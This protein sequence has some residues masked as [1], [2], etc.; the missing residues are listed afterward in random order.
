MR[1]RV[2]LAALVAPALIMA[3]ISGMAQQAGAVF[4]IGVLSPAEHPIT[5]VFDAFRDAL[6]KLGYI[7]GRN[8][9][10]EYAF[11]AGDNSRLPALAEVLVRLAVDLIVTDGGDEVARIAHR[12]APNLPIV[13]ATSADPA[14]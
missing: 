4:R 8:L 12:A 13:M 1:R 14:C 3:P 2:L 5:R 6:L 9:T 7:E 11:A 10:I